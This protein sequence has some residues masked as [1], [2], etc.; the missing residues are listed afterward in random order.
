MLV[1]A[2][3]SALYIILTVRQ[4]R[5]YWRYLVL[6]VWGMMTVAGGVFA[7][8]FLGYFCPE[9]PLVT[10][11]YFYQQL[12][13][14]VNASTDFAGALQMM[15][16]KISAG[17]FSGFFKASAPVAPVI[18]CYLAAAFL[19][20]AVGVEFMR[21]KKLKVILILCLTITAVGMVSLYQGIKINYFLS[22][23]IA[24]RNYLEEVEMLH[25]FAVRPAPALT[26]PE[27][28]A[29]VRE[30]YFTIKQMR[31]REPKNFLVQKLW[32]EPVMLE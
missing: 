9:L 7:G 14:C 6:T 3:I 5:Y 22:R 21:A 1:W 10:R 30:Y 17:E 31:H 12:V 15:E 25:D 11:A 18:L 16:Q 27:I 8:R 28:S 19:L 4:A 2:G 20:A 13:N 24:W 26:P 32:P 29:A 23:N